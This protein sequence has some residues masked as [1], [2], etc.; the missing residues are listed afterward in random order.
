MIELPP[1]LMAALQTEAERQGKTVS[2]IAAKAIKEWID[3][4]PWFDI[5][6][7]M[8][9]PRRVELPIEG[10]TYRAGESE[11]HIRVVSLRPLREPWPP[12]PT[13]VTVAFQAEYQSDEWEGQEHQFYGEEW[14]D[15]V[16]EF[17]LTLE[18]ASDAG[19][20]RV[21]EE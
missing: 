6:E 1:D 12:P 13:V 4:E 11:F 10:A 3:P 9:P 20:T 16:E 18:S 21:C 14:M 19:F 2:E 17:G 8:E 7:P 5:N 15:L